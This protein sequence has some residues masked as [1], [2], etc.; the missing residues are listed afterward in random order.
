MMNRNMMNSMIPAICL[1]IALSIS[2]AWAIALEVK[3]IEFECEPTDETDDVDLNCYPINEEEINFQQDGEVIF[4]LNLDDGNRQH[5]IAMQVLEDDYCLSADWKKLVEK[6]KTDEIQACEW[7]EE[8]V[9]V[10]LGKT[11]LRRRARTARCSSRRGWRCS[12]RTW[13]CEKE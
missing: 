13:Y 2:S 8:S 10:S 5:E 9:I 6:G 7:T 3:V 1:G 12:W 11:N 4:K